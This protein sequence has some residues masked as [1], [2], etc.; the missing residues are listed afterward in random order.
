MAKY[1][2][3]SV[4]DLS[5]IGQTVYHGVKKIPC[6]VLAIKKNDFIVEVLDDEYVSKTNVLIRDCFIKE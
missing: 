4:F 5:I 1:H 3:L 6:K 2:K